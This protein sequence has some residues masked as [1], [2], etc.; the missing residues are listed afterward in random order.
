MGELE[1]LYSQKAKAEAVAESQKTLT[2]Q[3]LQVYNTLCKRICSMERLKI[4]EQTAPLS[5]DPQKIKD[6][7]M[8]AKEIIN[9]VEPRPDD[10]MKSLLIKAG[11][12]FNEYKATSVQ[13]YNASF[14]GFVRQF[15]VLWKKQNNY[16]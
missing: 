11:K 7:W 1:R 2:P 12:L 15:V 14:K 5:M 3:Q 13:S 8:A 6:H 16:K 4:L 9:E 10:E